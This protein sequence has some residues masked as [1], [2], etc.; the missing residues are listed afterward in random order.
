M[1]L[2][3]ERIRELKMKPN[4]VNVL[5]IIYKIEYVD[6]PSDV[7]IYKRKSLWGQIDYWTRSIRI[8]DNGRN[9]EDVFETILHEL[10][11]A[12]GDALKLSILAE[13]KNHDQLDVLALAL[14]DLMTRN[15]WIKLKEQNNENEVEM[16]D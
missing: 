4:E 16:V 9:P 3:G 1:N 12:I 10:L 14:T 8:Y 2:N 15:N 13:D 11:H 7:D 6:N 5:G